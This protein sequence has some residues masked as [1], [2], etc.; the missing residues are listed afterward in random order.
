MSD[1]P[2]RNGRPQQVSFGAGTVI[3]AGAIHVLSSFDEMRGLRTVDSKDRIREIIE[4]AGN[5]GLTLTSGEVLDL[6][7]IGVL[8]SAA[9]AAGAVVMGIYALRRHRGAPITLAGL[10][11]LVLLGSVFT[12]PVMGMVL[13]A[14]TAMLWTGP[15]RDWFAGRAVR[16]SRTQAALGQGLRNERSP[17]PMSGGQAGGQSGSGQ[18]GH[19][20]DRGEPQPPAAPGQVPSGGPSGGPVP[21]E[22]RPAGQYYYPSSD[23]RPWQ[24]AQGWGPAGPGVPAPAIVKAAALITIVASALVAMLFALCLVLLAVA[25][26]PILNEVRKNADFRELDLNESQL[27]AVAA[28]ASVVLLVW[29]LIAIGLAVLT[30]RGHNWARIVL[31]LSTVVMVLL[32][33]LGIPVTLPLLLAGLAV[34]MA[35]V[36]PPARGYFRRSGRFG[37][38]VPPA[39]PVPGPHQW[40]DQWPNEWGGQ[41]P[42]QPPVAPGRSPYGEPGQRPVAPG[43]SPYGQ[44]GQPPYP[45]PPPGAEQPAYPGH[46]SGHP[47]GQP[48]GRR[49]GEAERPDA[50]PPPAAPPEDPTRDEDGKPPVW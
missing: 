6:M 17:D 10:S 39:G 8:V 27:V 42:G 28:A 7:H 36:A 9:A 5:S 20:S 50:G 45:A 46:P 25:R 21:W 22:Q 24:P 33:L 29:S 30:W 14:G 35:L 49:P 40:P 3:A 19:G 34:L 13:A 48:S 2:S 1:A 12:D 43:R 37:A 44:P 47:S 23:R 31:I 4:S 41:Q 15:A 38:A 18:G 26:E 16:P 32:C 11:I